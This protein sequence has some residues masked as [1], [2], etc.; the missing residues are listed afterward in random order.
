LERVVY[1]RWVEAEVGTETD[2]G[3][4]GHGSSGR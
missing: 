4:G 2:R 3:T 1:G